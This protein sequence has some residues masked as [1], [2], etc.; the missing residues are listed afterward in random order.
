M[1]M[2]LT[3]ADVLNVYDELDRRMDID[4]AHG[5][6]TARQI[7]AERTSRLQGVY[8]TL[9]VL[10]DNWRDVVSWTSDIETERYW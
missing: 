8:G 10:A 6:F 4:Y 7:S 5:H 3:K 9:K 2:T 1:K